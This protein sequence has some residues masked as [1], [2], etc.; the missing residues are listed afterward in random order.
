MDSKLTYSSI[1]STN[2]CDEN[3]SSGSRM[4]AASS[5]KGCGDAEY[6]H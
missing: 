1:G 5:K 2:R 4:V 3:K 6:L